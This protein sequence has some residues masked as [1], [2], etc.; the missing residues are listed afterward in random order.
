MA[1]AIRKPT[2][3]K[4][5]TS[6]SSLVR[7]VRLALKQV[8]KDD[9][10]TARIQRLVDSE[11]G[12][13]VFYAQSELSLAPYPKPKL[14][15]LVLEALVGSTPLPDGQPVALALKVIGASTLNLRLFNIVARRAIESVIANRRESLRAGGELSADLFEDDAKLYA[16]I[17]RAG[18]DVLGVIARRADEA[19][20]G[21]TDVVVELHGWTKQ[22]CVRKTHG[23]GLVVCQEGMHLVQQI[24]RELMLEA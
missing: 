4:K 6:S 13:P 11:V 24:A 9:D 22:L 10:L 15:R 18:A 8:L 7:A 16:S 1:L 19:V 5:H 14:S 2:F 12:H 21:R 20:Q 3:T 17:A 23:F